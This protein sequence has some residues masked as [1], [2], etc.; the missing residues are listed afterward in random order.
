MKTERGEWLYG[1]RPVLEVLRAGKR[2]MHEV[3]MQQTRDFSDEQQEIIYLAKQHMLTVKSVRREEL[4]AL[5]DRGHHQGVAIR[6]GGFPYCGIED[7]LHMVRNR[8]DALVL[9]LDHLEDPQNV[10]SLL[11]SAEAA[12]VD[13]VIIPEDRAVGIT[14]A[15]VRAS[16]GA[17]EHLAVA[18]V[19][20]VVRAMQQLQKEN[21]WL[22]GLD[23]T[24]DSKL[25][26]ELDFKGRCGIV[27]GAEGSGLTR[28][29]RETCDFIGRLPMLGKTES[30][31][32]GVAG[33]IV[34]FEVVRQ[35]SRKDR[36]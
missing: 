7:V 35:Q 33:G 3:L 6:T 23:M 21:M 11:R 1:K 8:E 9:I 26:T 13:A 18:K 15:A 22:T 14:P 5:T 34:L 20:N 28:L 12:G 10:G 19:V 24:S 2:L 17:S 36:A 25:V 29:A 31:N 4:D 16:A 27:V 30:L 32:A